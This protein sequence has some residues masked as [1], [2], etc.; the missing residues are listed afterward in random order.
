MSRLRNLGEYPVRRKEEDL[1]VDA[2]KGSLTVRSP[3]KFRSV[4]K[5]LRGA[6]WDPILKVWRVP[7]NQDNWE[8]LRCHT[9]NSIITSKAGQLIDK[10]E[11]RI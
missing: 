4:L 7:C 2:S 11:E 3:I 10:L 5:T 6:R 1:V 9:H 8:I